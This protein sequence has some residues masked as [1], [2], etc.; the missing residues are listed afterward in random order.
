MDTSDLKK[1]Y[2]SLRKKH[3]LPTFS[4]MDKDFEIYKVDRESDYLIRSIRKQIMEKI[5][6][7]L[8]FVEML[9]SGSNAPRMY[10]GYLKSMNNEERKKLEKIYRS[11]AELVVSS[12][13][14]EIEYNEKEEVALVKKISKSWHAVRNDFKKILAMVR[15]PIVSE[16]KTSSARK[17][18][19]YFG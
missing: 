4:E 1:E 18:R 5:V 9:L 2:E 10:Y 17:E 11:F 16:K 8:G 7:S 15:E 3:K 6:N 19:S 13:E 14:R 12:L